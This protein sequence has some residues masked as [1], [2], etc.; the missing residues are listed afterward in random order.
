MMSLLL[1][2]VLVQD[3]PT[4][5]TLAEP[6][7]QEI[8][9]EPRRPNTEIRDGESVLDYVYRNSRLEAGMLWTTFDS[10]LG[11]ESDFAWFARY[12]V[13]ISEILEVNVT[14]RQYDF[15]NTD[16]PAAGKEGL[17]IRGLFA[18]LGLK[19]PFATDFE[20]A[21]NVLGGAMWWHSQDVGF[22]DAVGPAASAEAS[23]GVRLDP[24]VLAR[25]GG[26]VDAA[27]SDFHATSTESSVSW[28]LL[29][30]FEF[31]VR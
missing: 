27:W 24:L 12:G 5:L 17:L 30:G 9:D 14:F 11:I 6:A 31:G 29:V 15:Y 10:D 1:A 7:R 22:D 28:S 18:G 2:A 8:E 3:L 4:S 20:F 26:A 25:V 23:L 21:A 19:I 16:L 13:G